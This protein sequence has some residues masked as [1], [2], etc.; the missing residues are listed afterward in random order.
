MRDK[1]IARLSF[2]DRSSEDGP[3]RCGSEE[4]GGD[5]GGR[6]GYTRKMIEGMQ[7][8]TRTIANRCRRARQQADDEDEEC[9]AS[10]SRST[11]Q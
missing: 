2:I 8:R 7:P 5:G 9:R 1:T 11:P 6:G 10:V 4:D 3:E